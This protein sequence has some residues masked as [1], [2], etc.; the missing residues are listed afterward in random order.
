MAPKPWTDTQPLFTDQNAKLKTARARPNHNKE[1]ATQDKELRMNQQ[2]S[3][4][5]RQTSDVKST[6]NQGQGTQEKLKKAKD[7]GSGG[8]TM[9]N[10]VQ[11]K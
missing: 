10:D 5:S 2:M 4:G 8:Q 3:P 1:V 9:T 7:K 6:E 11:G